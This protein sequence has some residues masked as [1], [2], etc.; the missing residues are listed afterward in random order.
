[1]NNPPCSPTHLEEWI[2]FFLADREK[3]GLVTKG[4]DVFWTSDVEPLQEL[5]L[6]ALEQ[7]HAIPSLQNKVMADT[8]IC[9]TE[10]GRH[11]FDSP[12][13]TSN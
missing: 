2:L 9:L 11:Y 1:M 13:K 8:T 12:N 3:Q 6:I 5:G 10:K 4:K 7:S